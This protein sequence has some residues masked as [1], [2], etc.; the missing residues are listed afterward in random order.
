[1]MMKTLELKKTIDAPASA[2]F[3]A[4]AQGQLLRST[5][6]IEKTFQ[7]T[8]KV[9]GEYSLNWES[10]PEASCTGRYLEI[11]P[12]K[13]VKFTWNSRDCSGSTASETTVTVHL[14]EHN[15]NCELTLIHE[16]LTDGTCHDEHL[17]GWTYT[18][19][20]LPKDVVAVSGAK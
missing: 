11:V 13:L 3:A 6:I 4:I 18:L 1:M 14:K 5:A 15:G 10:K 7:H 12:S 19:E 2:V 8:F 16:G 9:G 20:R 17:K